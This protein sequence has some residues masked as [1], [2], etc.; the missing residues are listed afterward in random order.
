MS[1]SSR[2]LICSNRKARHRY[3]IEETVEAGI[4]LLGPEVKS[5]RAGG[6][7]LT[8]GYA[9]IRRGEIFLCSVHIA[10]YEEASRENAEPTRDRKLLLHR[11]EIDRLSGKVRE[12]GF[13]L[14]P[15]DLYFRDGRAKVTLALARGKRTVD[16]R[17]EIAR[18]DAERQMDRARKQ[19]LRKR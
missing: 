13:T 15:L 8:D 10:P 3:H 5:L 1:E 4:S 14:I 7:A 6:A 17:H 12:R 16:R 19:R 18:R 9:R 11:R 2:K